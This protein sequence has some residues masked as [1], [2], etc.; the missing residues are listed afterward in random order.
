M[1]ELSESIDRQIKI[2]TDWLRK[3]E[4][5]VMRDYF[6]GKLVA[7]TEMQGLIESKGE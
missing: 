6:L 2:T 4:D 5:H 7:Y 3:E 1:K